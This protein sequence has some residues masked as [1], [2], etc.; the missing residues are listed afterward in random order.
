MKLIIKKNIN[1]TNWGYAF[2]KRIVFNC[3]QQETLDLSLG[4]V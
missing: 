1:Y 4:T 3:H 2:V